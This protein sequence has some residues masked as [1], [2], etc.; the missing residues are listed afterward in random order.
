MA[1]LEC[2]SYKL[3]RSNLEANNARRTPPCL[4]S[5]PESRR[6]VCENRCF[7]CPKMAHRRI[8]RHWE[9]GVR[10]TSN[11]TSNPV[12]FSSFHVISINFLARAKVA[13]AHF[14]PV[15]NWPIGGTHNTSYHRWLVFSHYIKL[16][17]TI[18]PTKN[19]WYI[20]YYL[21]DFCDGY[22]LGNCVH[23]HLIAKWTS[24]YA[25]ATLLDEFSIYIY[26]MCA[27]I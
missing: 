17:P 22:H 27:H 15:I 25:L 2:S 11:L 13:V 26:S 18:I 10:F 8:R 5:R 20:N 23:S 3:P 21:P 14:F 16:Y 6:S 7:F 9:K 1:L 19:T 12:C 4:P 24:L